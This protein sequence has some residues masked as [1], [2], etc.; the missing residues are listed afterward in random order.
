MKCSESNLSLYV[1]GVLDDS[2]TASIQQHLEACPLCRQKYSEYREISSNLRQMG[3]PEIS[4]A[5]KNSIKQNVCAETRDSQTT[6][7]PFSPDVREWLQMRVMPYGV[8]VFASFLIGVTFL[9]MM[10]SRMLQ[11]DVPMARGGDTS[12]MLAGNR[13]PY[14]GFDPAEISPVDY[15]Q[16]RL[17]FAS[18]SPSINPRGALIALTKSLVRGGMKDDEVVVVAEVFGNGL[19]RI[20]EVVEPSRDR[21]AVSELEKA[22]DSDP[23]YA[24]FVPNT[25]ENRPESVR[26]VLKFQ[27]VDVSTTLKRRK[28]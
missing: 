25:M 16:T 23:A 27:S 14:G 8:G 17:G 10:F 26:V 18:E 24:P 3:R 1:D 28:L 21:Q 7:L 12:V 2:E 5:L 4:I 6:W 20:D 15:A 9:T 11:P 13:N 19:A 22:L